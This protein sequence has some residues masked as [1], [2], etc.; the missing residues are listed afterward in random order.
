MNI[1]DRDATL[2]TFIMG[3][4]VDKSG[5]Q[6]LPELVGELTRTILEHVIDVVN[7]YDADNE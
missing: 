2:R 1:E 4:L 6:L 7:R 3:A 5:Q